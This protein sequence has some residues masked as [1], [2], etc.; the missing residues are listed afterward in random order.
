ME[1][2]IFLTGLAVGYLIGLVWSAVD[3]WV[4]RRI[5]LGPKPCNK[6]EGK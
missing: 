2:P 4:L 6:Q 3:H 1:L 5:F